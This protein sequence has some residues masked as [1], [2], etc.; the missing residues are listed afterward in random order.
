MA[1]DIF[2]AGNSAI[3]SPLTRAVAVTPSDSVDLAFVTRE[4]W[5]GTAGNLSLEMHGGDSIVITGVPAGARLPYRVSRVNATST[6]ATGIVAL[7]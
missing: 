4:L 1:D 2:A 3:L 6:T 7:W 5:V